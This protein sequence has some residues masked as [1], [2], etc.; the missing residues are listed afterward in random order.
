MISSQSVLMTLAQEM[1]LHL[2]FLMWKKLENN[3]DFLGAAM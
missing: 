2:V 3:I 1:Y